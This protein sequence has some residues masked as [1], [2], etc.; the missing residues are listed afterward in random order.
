MSETK[1]AEKIAHDIQTRLLP[2]AEEL[3]QLVLTQIKKDE[4]YQNEWVASRD[5][6]S[7][8]SGAGIVSDTHANGTQ[9]HDFYIRHPEAAPTGYDSRSLGEVEVNGLDSITIKASCTERRALAL[10]TFL[11]SDA[12]LKA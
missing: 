8:A 12:Y 3:H 7:I 5:R 10:I 11:R 6:L 2:F 4:D 1:S 9:R